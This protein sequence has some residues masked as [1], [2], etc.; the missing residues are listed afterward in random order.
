MK[1]G[2]NHQLSPN[3]RFIDEEP[4]IGKQ[5]NTL[6]SFPYGEKNCYTLKPKEGK[7]N[8]YIVRAGFAYKNYD[9][10][11]DSPIFKVYLGVDY[12]KTI[13]FGDNGT[14]FYNIVEVIHFSSTDSI[15]VCLE[16]IGKGTPFISLLEL[17]LLTNDTYPLSSFSQPLELMSRSV[18]RLPED[19]DAHFIR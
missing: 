2:E 17:W 5:L 4:Y 1:T 16:N 9:Q 11:N 19:E 15:D 12:G 13:E 18:F 8:K 6:R 10:K 14:S 3:N 7:N